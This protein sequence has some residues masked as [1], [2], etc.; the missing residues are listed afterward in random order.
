MV[1]TVSKDGLGVVTNGSG[2]VPRLERRIS[3][4]KYYSD[5]P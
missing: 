3:L 4:A 2:V 5:R 1:G